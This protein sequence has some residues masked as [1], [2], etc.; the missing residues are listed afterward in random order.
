MDGESGD[1]GRY[2]FTLVAIDGYCINVVKI[3]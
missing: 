1:D 2:E 3:Y